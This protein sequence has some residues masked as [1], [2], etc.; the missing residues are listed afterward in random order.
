VSNF[1]FDFKTMSSLISRC[2]NSEFASLGIKEGDVHVIRNAGGRAYVL[3][4]SLACQELN[5]DPVYSTDAIRS[6]VLSHQLFD[7]SEIIVYHHTE[8]GVTTATEQQGR[9]AIKS[10]VPKSSWALV[11]S[12]ALLV[13]SDV[14]KSIREDVGFLKEH[15]LIT[16]D[17]TITGW[18]YDTKT[19]AVSQVI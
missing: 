18:K 5:P 6:V 13:F 15:P 10:K 14:D 3:H 4:S 1:D 11:D 19:G 12:M 8:C 2:R 16:K 7:S 17:T 9:D